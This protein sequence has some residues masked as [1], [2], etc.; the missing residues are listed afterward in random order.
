MLLIFRMETKATGE[1]NTRDVLILA[2]AS[3]VMPDSVLPQDVALVPDVFP[4]QVN[5]ACFYLS[6]NKQKPD[7]EVEPSKCRGFILSKCWCLFTSI[8]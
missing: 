8:Y 2:P 4:R 1:N 6:S 7:L 3:F 5:A